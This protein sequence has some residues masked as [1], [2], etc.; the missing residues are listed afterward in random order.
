MSM[1]C[2]KPVSPS[3]ARH[4]PIAS[5]GK[6]S[7]DCTKTNVRSTVR[8]AQNACTESRR[9]HR[10]PGVSF[11]QPRRGDFEPGSGSDPQD[12]GLA[13]F[14]AHGARH[15]ALRPT[16]WLASARTNR[17]AEDSSSPPR[18]SPGC[19]DRSRGGSARARVRFACTLRMEPRVDSPSDS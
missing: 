15:S 4:A 8:N 3:S 13:I 10:S 12:E 11:N 9:A 6:V 19:R 5:T 17:T 7:H 1:A 16:A 18:S 14:S 2:A